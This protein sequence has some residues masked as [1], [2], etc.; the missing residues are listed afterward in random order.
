MIVGESP[1]QVSDLVNALAKETDLRSSDHLA[2]S[3]LQTDG[4]L[5]QMAEDMPDTRWG[6]QASLLLSIVLLL[7]PLLLALPLK[8][9]GLQGP[10]PN[11]GQG[12]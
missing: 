2:W 12:R 9:P 10:N 4:A 11:H 1:D 6:D 3:Y 8:L 5:A 7:L